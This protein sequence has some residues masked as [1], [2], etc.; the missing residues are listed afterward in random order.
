MNDNQTGNQGGSPFDDDAEQEV[1]QQTGRTHADGSSYGKFTLTP[2][3]DTRRKEL[4][5]DVRPIIPVIFLPGVMGSLLTDKVSGEELF[6]A[7]NTDGMLGNLGALPALIGLW[8]TSAS[9]RET[10]FDPTRAAVTPLGPINVGKHGKDDTAEQFVDEAEARRR[11]WGSIHR[12]SYHPVL[13]WLE[14]QLN[15]PMLMGKPHGAWVETDPKGEK[16]TLKPVIDTDPADYGALGKGGKITLDS[17]EF[18]HFS[19]YRYRVYAIGYN[20][21]QSNADSGRQVVEGSD[22]VDPKTQKKTRLMG[23][24][25]I[26]AENDSGKAIVLTHSMGG[27]VA[28]MA[29]AMHGAEDLIHGVF[30]NVQPATG[31]P[32][33][34]KRFRTG[35]GNEGGMNSFINGSLVG[36]DADEFVAVIANAP[37]PLELIPMPD[38]INGEPWWVF[39]RLNGEVVMQL[40]KNGDAYNEIYLNSNWYGLVP[41]PSLL[42]PAGTVKKQ[43]DKAGKGKTVAENFWRTMQSVVDKQHEIKDRYHDKTYVAYNG[44]GNLKKNEADASTEGGGKHKPSIEK[45][46]P[47]EELLTFG[48][49]IWKGNIPPGVTEEELRA[50]RFMRADDSH[51]GNVRVYLDSR[52]LSVDF[53]VQKVA[54]LPSGATV[55]DPDKN[56]IISGDGTVP[57]WSADAQARGLTPEV[58]GNPAKGVQMAFVQGGYDHQGSYNH[59]W[60]RWALLYSIVQIAQDAPEPSC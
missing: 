28:R 41:D 35:G 44:I 10:Q 19:K 2:A 43:L 14:E 25:E 51:T 9:S 24:R 20:W 1:V 48:K 36:R 32:V 29:I 53:E 42:D 17:A 31:A 22:Y 38:Y 34:V 50:A 58:E 8:F 27:L 37:G 21:L 49:V 15:Q 40:P 54:K 30:H 11:G 5:C 7:P 52:K 46:K 6:F 12:T 47:L 57:A 23:I 45:G 26:I 13:A 4:L 55:P 18:K 59:P 56:G 39:A 33:A 16:W 60:T 3:S